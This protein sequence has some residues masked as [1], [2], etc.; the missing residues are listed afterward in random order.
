MQG[1]PCI[2]EGHAHRVTNAKCRIDKVISPDDGHIVARNMW[3][4]E[5]NILRK[6]V[7]QFFGF[8]YK[9]YKDAGQQNIKQGKVICVEINDAVS[10]LD[11]SFRSRSFSLIF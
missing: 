2:P 3:R 4:T 1:A 5:I 11:E 7:H 9:I 6:I 8:S 10:L